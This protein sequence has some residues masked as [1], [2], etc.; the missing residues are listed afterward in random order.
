MN[1]ITYLYIKTH[2]ITG[3]KYFGKTIKDPFE[4]IGS[5]KYWNNHLKKH[6]NNVSTKI[7]A[8]FTAEHREEM[9]E[10]ALFFSD[11][12]DIV[13]SNEWANLVEENGL[14]GGNTS[15]YRK[16]I[17]KVW[18]S[19]GVNEFQIN[20]NIHIVLNKNWYFGRA[21]PFLNIE[22]KN[23]RCHMLG[24]KGKLCPHYG[25][26]YSDYTKNLIR[27]SQIGGKWIN[28]GIERMKIFNW[29]EENFIMPEGWK[30]GMQIK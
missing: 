12:F 10:F 11:Y 4:Y 14:A 30:F 3:L 22:Y 25:K 28:N 20:K 16:N 5:G 2:N 17:K 7:V 6:G 8:S 13:K 21:K 23:R 26:K 9:I 24:K 15:K 19:N 27:Q 1:K 18:V 29:S